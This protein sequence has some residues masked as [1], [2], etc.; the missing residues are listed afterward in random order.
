VREQVDV[1]R[2]PVGRML[3]EPAQAR[4]EGDTWIIPL[5]EEVL[6]VKK[7]FLLKEEVR[8]TRRSETVNSPQSVTLRSEDVVIERFGQEQTA[9]QTS[10]EHRANEESHTPNP[11]GSNPPNA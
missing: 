11:A 2:V 8:I 1:E 3:D 4:Q 6:E 5:M 9:R 7:R 10:V